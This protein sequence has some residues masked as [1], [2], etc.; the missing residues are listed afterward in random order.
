MDENN[1]KN[2]VGDGLCA[3]PKLREFIRL[4]RK[5]NVVSVYKEV[6][7]DTETPVSAYLKLNPCGCSY[8]LES[9][10]GEE[11]VA[12]FS[13]L[14]VNPEMVFIARGDNA[15]VIRYRGKRQR[16]EVFC[17]E[18]NPLSRLQSIVSRLRL[19]PLKGLPRFSAGFV[20]YIGYDA[21]GFFEP[22]LLR[23]AKSGDRGRGP[24]P[25]R[26]G[27]GLPDVYFVLARDLLVFDHLRQRVK[28]IV[29]AYIPAGGDTAQDRDL[30]RIYEQAVKSIE[31]LEGILRRPLA[32]GCLSTGSGQGKGIAKR[33]IRPNIDRQAFK[34]M[35]LRAKEYIRRGEV[36]QVVLSQ[37]FSCEIKQPAFEVYRR[38][39]A[40]NPSPYMYYLNFPGVCLAGASPEMF[41]RC[42]QG[43]AQMRPIAGTRPRGRDDKED[44]ALADNLLRDK[45]ER[46]EH[47]MLVDLGRNDLGRVCDYGTVKI[48]EFM[49][50]E[51]YSHVMHIVSNLSGKMNSRK[52]IFDLVAATFPA[53]TVSGAPKIRAMQIIDD[54]EKAARGPYA[55]CVGY[56]GLNGNLDTCITI[57]T[58]VIVEG[59]GKGAGRRR[60]YIQAGAGIVADSDPDKEYLETLNK[61]RAQMEAI[62]VY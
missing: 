24:K 17:G 55:G 39:R 33:K 30:G 40:I 60:A 46:A 4:C 59:A 47:L 13:F 10:E 27:E 14:G 31:R 32:A 1:I 7:A 3:V 15:R 42:E 56:I 38:L 51:K 58:V 8:L 25:R 44:V 61:A 28:I 62:L 52:N 21:V 9:V 2:N 22:S 37:R 5:W 29:N 45:K 16:E 53:G 26:A 49:A 50:V 36:I 20:G 35:V 6:I 48:D 34:R 41:V 23:Q 43:R 54:L 19:A 57:R 12:R 18:A 11:K